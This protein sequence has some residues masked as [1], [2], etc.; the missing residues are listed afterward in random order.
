MPYILLTHSTTYEHGG[1]E[2]MQQLGYMT[3]TLSHLEGVQVDS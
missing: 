2:D 3:K 1:L